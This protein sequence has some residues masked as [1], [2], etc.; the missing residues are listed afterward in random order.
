MNKKYLK[1]SWVIVVV[2]LFVW[3][4]WPAE[5]EII[6]PI[7]PNV[8][9][10]EVTTSSNQE[11]M[12][13]V[14]FIQPKDVYEATFGTIGTIENIYVSLGQSVKVGTVLASLNDQNARLNVDNANQ[15]YDIALSNQKQAR[16]LMQAEAANL[17]NERQL[18]SQRVEQAKETLDAS[19]I[20]YEQAQEA[21]NN[22]VE[23]HGETSSEAIEAQA[24][25][26]QREIER[27]AAQAVFNNLTSEDPATLSI[28]LSRYEASVAAY[29][30]A[31]TQASIALNNVQVAQNQLEDTRLKSGID[32]KVVAIIQSVGELATPLIP[33]VVIAS[34][35][36]VAVFGLSQSNINLVNKSMPATVTS[37][38][39][40]L[41][42]TI[43]NISFIPDETSRTYEARVEVGAVADVNIGETVQIMINLGETD[44]VWLDLSLLLN[45]GE[46]YVYVVVDDRIVKRVV[47][48]GSIQNQLVLVYN[49]NEG[50]LVVVEGGQSLKVGTKVNVIREINHD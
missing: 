35:E 6:E 37:G 3:I 18:Q 23:E 31:T 26:T 33:T 30:S 25:L 50:D 46:D 19:Q 11:D 1:Y 16:A 32:G 41:E 36:L 21:Y 24:T 7:L 10:M 20:A 43:S 13:F 15:Q 8:R 48:R 14:G 27:N 12:K 44:G 38:T 39:Q 2:G 34:D 22:A 9:V 17:E 47:K 29:Q 4:L 42:G 49:L 28:A 5:E 45:D 40:T